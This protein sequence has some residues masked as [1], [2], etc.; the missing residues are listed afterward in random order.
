MALQMQELSHIL[1]LNYVAMKLFS[2]K[3]F[4]HMVIAC[5]YTV[6]DVVKEHHTS[7]NKQ[8]SS[9]GAFYNITKLLC[10]KVE[11]QATQ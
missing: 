6:N 9:K 5:Q 7:H 8:A 4:M 10:S 11:Q 3:F 1:Y 2:L